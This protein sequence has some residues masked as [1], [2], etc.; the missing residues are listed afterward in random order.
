[1]PELWGFLKFP[2]HLH[3]GTGLTVFFSLVL[4][5]T[6]PPGSDRLPR[7]SRSQGE[8]DSRRSRSSWRS[9]LGLRALAWLVCGNSLWFNVPALQTGVAQSSQSLMWMLGLRT[10]GLSR[11]GCDQPESGGLIWSVGQSAVCGDE[12]RGALAAIFQ[13]GTR[14]FASCLFYCCHLSG[15]C[16][17]PQR[18]Q[19]PAEAESLASFLG[20]LGNVSF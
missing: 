17:S 15:F 8:R 20:K 19:I 11:R 6:W 3:T 7:S 10:A 4:G 16:H 14:P 18:Q 9:G 13:D 12:A 2:R 1:M 5:S